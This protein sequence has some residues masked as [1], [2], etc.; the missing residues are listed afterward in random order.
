MLFKNQEWAG[1]LID[2]DVIKP[3][4]TQRWIDLNKLGFV[5]KYKVPLKRDKV[6]NRKATQV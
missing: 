5:T 6:S 3:L 1:C 4:E 2:I